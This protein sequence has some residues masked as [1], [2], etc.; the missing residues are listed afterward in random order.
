[1]NTENS[2]KALKMVLKHLN[3][4]SSQFIHHSNRGL[5]YWA[6]EYQ[7][8]LNKNEIVYSMTQN[9][10]SYENAVAERINGIL[11]QEFRIIKYNQKA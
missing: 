1:M 6:N 9:S 2:L 4:K 11:K 8:Q 5:R 3:N 7:K 10:D